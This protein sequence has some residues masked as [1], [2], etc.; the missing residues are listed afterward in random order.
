MRPMRIWFGTMLVVLGVLWLLDAGGVLDAQDLLDRWWPLAV[1]ALAGLAMAA[2]RRVTLG[3]LVLAGIGAVLLIDQL[4][5]VDTGTV[6]WP[7]IA[8]I[9]GVWII[10]D[11][12]RRWTSPALERQNT[13]ALLGGSDIKNH[14]AHFRHANVSAVFGGATLD[15][16]S[17]HLDPGARVDALA[18]FGGVDVIVPPGWRVALDGLPIFGGYED[19]TTGNA[20][21][22]EDAPL[23]TVSATAIFGGVGVKNTPD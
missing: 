21:L 16:R 14:S 19:K 3:P 7:V 4:E 11:L 22:P 13:F 15:L 10:L 20:D 18:L 9:A 8:V 12:G 5:F 23:L 6:V 17:A 1:L 2:E